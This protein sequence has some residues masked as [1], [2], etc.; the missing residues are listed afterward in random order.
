MKKSLKVLSV[1]LAALVVF[2]VFGVS[3]S[4]ISSKSTPEE[5]FAYYEKALRKNSAKD[6]IRGENIYSTWNTYDYS[7]LSGKALEKAKAET[8]G[9]G[10]EKSV[11]E[12]TNFY[13]GDKFIEEY[14]LED[15]PFVS[16][17]DI[18]EDIKSHF[19]V[20]KSA[21]YTKNSDGSEKIVFRC[22]RDPGETPYRCT[23]TVR[24]SKT[25]Y[26]THYI[27]DRVGTYEYYTESGYK[28]K[29][30]Q[31]SVENHK[32]L[33][34]KVPVTSIE[35]SETAVDMD[36]MESKEIYVK[37]NPS[38]AT[39]KNYDVT[40]KGGAGAF[41]LT[42]T[43]DGVLTVRAMNDGVAT[44]V[45]TDMT[46]NVVATCTLTCKVGFFKRIAL[47]FETIFAL[48]FGSAAGF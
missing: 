43:E 24:I 26:V 37:I 22:E 28:I 31:H 16:Y 44:L 17:F 42:D 21:T 5:M 32:F 15:S 34:Q 47:F 38:D 27:E 8:A 41:Q 48:L 33:C 10:T 20:L 19:Y 7:G 9:E 23:Y 2:S 30:L 45:V 29:Q 11:Y 25:G 3:A 14:G 18:E 35:L 13:K 46:E 36:L 40:I 4:A 6:L 39:F 12:H 1:F